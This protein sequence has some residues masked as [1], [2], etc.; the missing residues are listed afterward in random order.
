[1]HPERGFAFPVPPGRQ[2]SGGLGDLAG[3]DARRAHAHGLADAVH[4]GMDALEVG[5]PPP[6]GDV[7]SVAH[8]IPIRRTFT[9]N[10]ALT[11]HQKLLWKWTI[12][13]ICN[14]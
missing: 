11:R 2:F 1:L 14:L 9:A 10:F 7:V 3:A 6:A 12:A 4:N 13:Q 5:V 8:V